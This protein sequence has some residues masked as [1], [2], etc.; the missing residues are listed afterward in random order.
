MYNICNNM[1]QHV[2]ERCRLKVEDKKLVEMARVDRSSDAQTSDGDLLKVAPLFLCVSENTMLFNLLFA[3]TAESM[4]MIPKMVSIEHVG[5]FLSSA[6]KMPKITVLELEENSDLM[7]FKDEA[8]L[9][10]TKT[11]NMVVLA[12]DVNRARATALLS[13]GVLS[14]VKTTINPK[15][16]M[17]IMQLAALSEPYVPHDLFMVGTVEFKDGKPNNINV[18]TRNA[19][20]YLE[21]NSHPSRREVDVLM[22]V[23]EGKTNKE[24]CNK[25]NI[26]EPTVKMHISRLMRR[27][28]VSNRTKLCLIAQDFFRVRTN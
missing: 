12:N 4:G 5:D 7:I 10:L 28:G 22:C 16:F 13:L 15:A 20:R 24:I 1:I 18:S 23:A 27:F 2:L 14:I 11:S 25:L 6:S 3:P 21:E 9:S 19:L 17:P 26:A 8:L